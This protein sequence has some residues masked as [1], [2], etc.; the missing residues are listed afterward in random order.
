M[1]T[2]QAVLVKPSLVPVVS[3]EQQKILESR[4]VLKH[5]LAPGQK[6]FESPEG[7]VMTGEADQGHVW[8]RAANGGKGCWINPMR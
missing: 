2:K 3:S 7:Y 4:E 5:P 6:Y 1:K 8:C